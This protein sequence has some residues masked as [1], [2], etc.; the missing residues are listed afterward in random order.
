[1]CAPI[2]LCIAITGADRIGGGGSSHSQLAPFHFV[3]SGWLA[4]RMSPAAEA[5]DGRACCAATAARAPTRRFAAL[6][7]ELHVAP[8]ISKP[9]RLAEKEAPALAGRVRALV[10]AASALRRAASCWRRR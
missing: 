8:P 7:L 9:L 6:V 10:A 5:L 2:S 3:V 1:M 4:L